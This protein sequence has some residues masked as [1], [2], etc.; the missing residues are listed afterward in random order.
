M[1][2]IKVWLA[3]L[4]LSAGGP[5]LA[6]G[7]GEIHGKVIDD[8]GAPLIFVN[9]IAEQGALRSGA[10]TDDQGR[11][12]LKPLPAGVYTV[13]TSFTGLIG[14]E[15]SQVRVDADL[16]NTMADIV[17][18]PGV[19]GAVEVKAY[20][21][22]EPLIRKDDPARMT[23]TASQIKTNAVRKDPVAMVAKFT[24]G[25]TKASNGDGLYFR[26]ARTDAMCYFVDGVKMQA[27][28]GVPPD[29]I[30][31]I[32]VYT[33]G[34]PAKYGD[35]TG[36]VVAIDTKSYFDLYQQRNAAGR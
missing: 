10:E 30:N 9:V 24:P 17:M 31:S 11:Y 36:G 3:A 19:M 18:A 35:V 5:L 2:T 23:I 8:E 1:G 26:G 6:Q 28:T 16:I 4:A 13:R 27:L 32:T 21:W 15:I 25:V 34:L 20:R 29:A 14:V 22:E 7:V 12:V 33:G